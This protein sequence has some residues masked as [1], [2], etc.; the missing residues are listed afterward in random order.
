MNK[1]KIIHIVAIDGTMEDIKNIQ[2]ELMPL[3]DKLPYEF[4]FSNDKI[5]L[6]DID[7]LINMLTALK[8]K[9]DKKW[10]Q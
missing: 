9:E 2:T 6:H 7:N 8:D 3:K 10:V 4:I 5:Q 1:A